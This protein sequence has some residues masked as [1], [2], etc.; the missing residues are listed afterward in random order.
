M[1]NGRECR[2]EHA[3]RASL[4]DA[5]TVEPPAAGRRDATMERERAEAEAVRAKVR[6][7]EAEREW[8][9]RRPREEATAEME[10]TEKLMH[11]LIWGPN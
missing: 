2:R 8:R 6:A 11:L 1:C 3:F 7:W 9:Q 4:E 10:R 5:K